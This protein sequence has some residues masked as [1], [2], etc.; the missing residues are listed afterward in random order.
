MGI[1]LTVVGITLI[2][3]VP[4]TIKETSVPTF[5]LDIIFVTIGLFILKSLP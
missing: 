4:N 2:R 5:L 3:L 1:F